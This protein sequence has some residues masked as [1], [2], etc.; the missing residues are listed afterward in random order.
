M[1]IL[2]GTAL[3][4]S[5][6]TVRKMSGLRQNNQSQVFERFAATGPD[7]DW[8]LSLPAALAADEEYYEVSEPRDGAQ[9]R[10][11]RVHLPVDGGPYDLVDVPSAAYLPS[12]VSV[13]ARGPQGPPGDLSLAGEWVA[14]GDYSRGAVVIHDNKAWVHSGT[15][16]GSIEPGAATEVAVTAPVSSNPWT[17][18][19]ASFMGRRLRTLTHWRGRIY[20]GYG[21]YGVNTGPIDLTYYVPETDQWISEGNL[22]GEGTNRYY[23]FNDG[24]VLF[25]SSIDSRESGVPN[26][27]RHDMARKF[28][29]GPWLFTGTHDPEPRGLNATHIF[30]FSEVPGVGIVAAGS[31]LEG[32]TEYF[33]AQLWFT[34]D[35]GETWE[36]V[37]SHQDQLGAVNRFYFTFALNGRFYAMLAASEPN[38]FL[39]STDGR[40]W[41]AIPTP[42]FVNHPT[43]TTLPPAPFGV[44]VVWN[45]EVVAIQSGDYGT[46]SATLY[47]FNGSEF[48]YIYPDPVLPA[49]FDDQ[50][51]LP[52]ALP[53]RQQGDPGLEGANT[54]YGVYTGLSVGDD[55]ELYILLNVAASFANGDPMVSWGNVYRLGRDFTTFELVAETPIVPAVQNTAYFWS[56]A[57]VEGKVYIGGSNGSLHV[58]ELRQAPWK[59]IS[60]SVVGPVGLTGPMGPRGPD[61]LGNTSQLRSPALVAVGEW[62]P[63]ASYRTGMVVRHE[64]QSWIATRP[65]TNKSPAAPTGPV[66]YFLHRPGTRLNGLPSTL[67]PGQN[68]KAR[69]FPSSYDGWETDRIGPHGAELGGFDGLGLAL[70]SQTANPSISVRS[71][72]SAE[73][74]WANSGTVVPGFDVHL[75]ARSV[76]PH[77]DVPGVGMGLSVEVGTFFS[78]STGSHLLWVYLIHRD[79]DSMQVLSYPVLAEL[80]VAGFSRHEHVSHGTPGYHYLYWEVD[81][82]PGRLPLGSTVVTSLLNISPDEFELQLDS[83]PLM[84][85][86]FTDQGPGTWVGWSDYWGGQSVLA[87]ALDDLPYWERIA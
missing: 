25:T 11:W 2:R 28:G 80:G 40:N 72:V 76:E 63:T 53:G 59:L 50:F 27:Q 8:K 62:S 66:E 29:D 86:R 52:S 57:V 32:P 20:G 60:D 45:G 16:D 24:E 41:E 17:A 44:S 10:V 14:S 33:P 69:F 78:N 85:F 81:I 61:R 19:N 1:P 67:I 22:N 71:T 77:F 30:D 47:R 12:P 46:G 65:S 54:P 68:W 84:R 83:V 51:Y 13:G 18:A 70:D 39:S 36:K 31:L 35:L 58:G 9:P 55:G 15:G 7:G 87:V 56:L 74:G 82:S 38:D 4:D 79:F 23:I 73:D 75:F 21:D 48:R 5:V 3:P 49:T 43:V 64:N 37:F 42:A 26:N 34:D 6:V